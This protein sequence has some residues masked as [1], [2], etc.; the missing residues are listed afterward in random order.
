MLRNF[1]IFAA[2]LV[3]VSFSKI[4]GNWFDYDFFLF[5]NIKIIFPDYAESLTFYMAF[6]ALAWDYYL[7]ELKYNG[8]NKLEMFIFAWLMTGE[9]ADYILRY[10]EVWFTVN[11]IWFTYQFS[12][13]S[14]MFIIFTIIIIRKLWMEE[15]HK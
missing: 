7:Q 9:L 15:I 2:L 10:S 8:N 3:K 14:F 1:I 11:T 13:D 6:G 5:S 4:E 12:Y